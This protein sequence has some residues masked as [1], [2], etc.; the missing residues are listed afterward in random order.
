MEGVNTEFSRENYAKADIMRGKVM[1]LS[2]L[3]SLMLGILSG[4]LGMNYTWVGGLLLILTLIISISL[5]RRANYYTKKSSDYFIAFLLTLF[6][7]ISFWI[8]ALNVT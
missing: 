8:I 5:I 2:F 7:F 4:L 1:L 6:T 3:I